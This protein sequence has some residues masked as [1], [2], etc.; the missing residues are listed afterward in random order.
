AKVDVDDLALALGAD[1]KT[2]AEA[3]PRLRVMTA[4]ERDGETGAAER[5]GEHLDQLEVADEARTSHLSIGHA[6][7]LDGGGAGRWRRGETLAARGEPLLGIAEPR[8]ARARVAR[9]GRPRA[10]RCRVGAARR[11]SRCRRAAFHPIADLLPSARF[12]RRALV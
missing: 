4:R 3:Q 6:D 11:R 8:L 10:R 1:R 9:A 5:A 7:A 12:P 2:G